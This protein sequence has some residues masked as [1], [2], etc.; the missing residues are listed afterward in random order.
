MYVPR[1]LGDTGFSIL[2]AKEELEVEL[3]HLIVP[4]HAHCFWSAAVSWLLYLA[5]TKGL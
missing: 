2:T 4:L 5:V 3:I 1:L